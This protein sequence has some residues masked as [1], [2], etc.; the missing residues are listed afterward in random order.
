M[1]Q[2][3][4]FVNKILT[5]GIDR[6]D[7][8]GV[9][10]RSIFGYDMRF[11]LDTFPLLTTKKVHFKSIVVEL[12]W[13]LKGST[14]IQWLRENKVKIW[15]EWADADGEL[16]PVY[17]YQW[18]S[19]PG[20]DG[21]AIDQISNLIDSIKNNPHSRRHIVNAWNVSM[22]PEMALPP[23]H[24]M[25]Q[26]YVADGKLS[27]KIIQR[28]ADAFLG[29]PFNIASYALLCHMIAHVTNLKAHEIIWSG[30]D[31]HIYHNHYDAVNTQL[32]RTPGDLPTLS[33]DP[34]VTSIFDFTPES[35]RLENY[36]PQ[37]RISAPIAV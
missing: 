2:Y 27:L 19:W 26:L 12:L 14:N 9:G 6:T 35:I 29:V 28:S 37:G 33:L 34:E 31:C 7:R 10:T 4:D 25:F 18:R 1:K 15:D 21:K 36:E 30:G 20:N 16:G 11:S 22:L 32:E 3:L 24:M 23:C 13:F 5:T 8:T 17:G